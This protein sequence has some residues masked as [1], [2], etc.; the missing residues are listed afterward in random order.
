MTR[1]R[2]IAIQNGSHVSIFRL[3][4]LYALLAQKKSQ[5][6]PIETSNSKLASSSCFKTSTFVRYIYLGLI[7]TRSYRVDFSTYILSLECRKILL[8]NNYW[9]HLNSLSD[10]SFLT[11]WGENIGGLQW[12]KI[13]VLHFFSFFFYKA[14]ITKKQYHF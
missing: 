10:S 11:W 6:K 5:R 7:S 13:K 12:G 9:Q 2:S 1:S 4:V 3:N 8:A 14:C